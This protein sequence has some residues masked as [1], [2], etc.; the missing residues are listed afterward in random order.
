MNIV[1]QLDSYKKYTNGSEYVMY[2]RATCEEFNVVVDGYGGIVKGIAR[3]L[4]EQ[5][6]DIRRGFEVR[7]GCTLCFNIVPLDSW[8]NPIDRR[9]EHLRRN[10]D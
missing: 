7:R 1:V 10:N 2:P 9:P 4:A 6:C 3:R 5:N 8:V